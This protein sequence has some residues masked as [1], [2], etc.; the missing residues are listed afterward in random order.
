MKKKLMLLSLVIASSVYANEDEFYQEASTGVKLQES[1][2]STTGF[3]TAQRNLA[4]TVTVITAKD[5]EE[6]NYNSVVEA[7]KDV[8][9]VNIIGN[10]KN[11][12]IDMRG[13]GDRANSNVQILIDGISTNLLDVSHA[14][15]PINTV[16]VENIEKIEVIPGGGAILYGS[17]TRGGIIN[18]ITKSGASAKGGY[19][20]TQLDS[21]GSKKIDLSYGT[22]VDKLDMNI[23]FNRNDY[24]GFRDGDELDSTFLET[25][26]R[27]RIDENQSLLGKFSR[28]EGEGTTPR[29]LSKD[30]LD[31]TSS[32]GLTKPLDELL[33]NETTKNE[34]NLKYDNKISENTKL[35]ILGFYQE[36]DILD[37]N[38]YENYGMAV[39]NNMDFTDKKF[40]IKPK[41]K[42]SYGENSDLILG[43]DYI[44]NDLDRF[45][46][47][48]IFS[49]EEYEN[50]LSKVTNSLFLLNRNNLGK[51]EFTQGIR[52]EHAKFTAD[53]G[54]RKI[55]SSSITSTEISSER[56]M[57]N[58]AYELV[59]NYLY[60]PSG[61]IYIKGEKGFTSPTPSQL[62][63]KVDGKYT[64]NDLDSETYLTLELGFKDYL[65]GSFVNGALFYTETKDEIYTENL[66]GM[67]FINHNIGKTE[68]YG[69][70]LNAQQSLGNFTFKEGYSLIKTKILKDSDRSIEGNNIANVPKNKFSL[71]FNY[72]VTPKLTF[73][74]E[75][76]YVSGIYINNQNDGGKLNSHIV[77]DIAVNYEAT[78]SLRLFAGIDNLFNEKYYDSISSKGTDYSPAAERSFKGGFKYSF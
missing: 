63:D 8:P 15:T 38:N 75:S 39:T 13:Q 61:N 18:I 66:T 49:P 55:G 31:N 68:R 35:E 74:W 45:S 76:S 11:P 72:Q 27:Y 25:S 9:S 53:R 12:V 2:V 43:Y 26:L 3:E 64:S 60:S 29:A 32:N 48:K 4:N 73:D 47:T 5:I 34:F 78:E 71:G 77:T 67:N 54:Y 69:L 10:P 7:L 59:G 41:L 21:F 44:K 37:I 57:E 42:F 28:Y 17:G 14:N 40:G 20:N 70:E 19:V 36:T 16:P 50:N 24:K 22:T 1:V 51:F 56:S 58:M 52:Y 23:N 33:K 30:N 62:V 6:K 65:L 46:Q